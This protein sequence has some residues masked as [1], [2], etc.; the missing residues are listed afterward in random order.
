[1]IDKILIQQENVSDD[2]Y[3]LIEVL[4]KSGDK[5]KK[6][7]HLFSYE[8]SKA[9]IDY[10]S[11]N[12]GFIYLNPSIK[13][14][15]FYEVGHQI[16]IISKSKLTSDEMHEYFTLDKNDE[17]QDQ[18]EVN[19]TKKALKLFEQSDLNISSFK[20]MSIVTEDHILN[21]LSSHKK[22]DNNK[23]SKQKLKLNENSII[24]YG[25]GSQADVVFD[26]LSEA[27]K[28]DTVAFVDFKNSIS[29]KE[30]LPVISHEYF[31]E[32]IQNNIVN[33][34]ICIPDQDKEEQ[35]LKLVKE[36][37]S[38]L[39]TVIDKSAVVSSKATI[40][41]N[42][43]IGPN[44]TLG[45]YTEIAD[46]VRMLNNSSVAH[47]SVIGSGSWISDGARIGGYVVIGKRC[48]IGLNSSI[49]KK[50]TIVLFL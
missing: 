44:C 39:I 37:N 23:A 22:R 32:I 50:T 27:G 38:K 19:F 49:N 24:I 25:I 16:A 42:V 18:H 40:G 30:N 4:C 41:E 36:S 2:E 31:E 47:H 34:Y 3:K 17:I 5:V 28:Y 1:M 26:I 10:E 46:S 20:G 12:N 8:S 13:I 6:D 33:V 43:F 14:D 15:E 9:V 48:L 45:P 7:Q 11:N 21:F 35:L 29:D